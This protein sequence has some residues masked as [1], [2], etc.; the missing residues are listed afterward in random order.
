MHS[1]H[2][3]VREGQ[4]STASMELDK[5]ASDA[6]AC[7]RNMHVKQVG[8]LYG[9]QGLH[10]HGRTGQGHLTHC[11]SL[12]M[13]VQVHDLRARDTGLHG[14]CHVGSMR[15]HAYMRNGGAQGCMGTIARAIG[16]H[17]S[18]PGYKVV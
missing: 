4:G 11:H 17:W 13:H 2:M 8:I 10:R 6:H 12:H 9:A 15:M 1:L 14:A 3:H 18:G 5:P 7:A 16:W